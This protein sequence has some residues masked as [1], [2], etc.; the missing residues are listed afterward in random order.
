MG[1]RR[2]IEYGIIVSEIREPR[3]FWPQFEVN[4]IVGFASAVLFAE[5][6]IVAE[7]FVLKDTSTHIGSQLRN[8]IEERD[9]GQEH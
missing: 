1:K 7:F 5:L 8:N 4:F 6:L 3:K 2:E 9:N